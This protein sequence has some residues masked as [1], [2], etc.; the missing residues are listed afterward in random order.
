MTG[1]QK[2]PGFDG[3]APK[4]V[5]D[6]GGPRFDGDICAGRHGGAP[7]S[8]DAFE[9]VKPSRPEHRTAVLDLVIA[10]GLR[11]ITS[12]EIAARLGLA[13][14][15]V[16]GR[17][18]ELKALG[19]VRVACKPDGTEYRRDRAAVLVAFNAASNC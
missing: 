5:P 14:H 12:K 6:A 4:H 9:A 1:E 17:C 15:K 7:A 13:L 18:S 19:L 16:S 3:P 11:G 10:A 8:V 2:L